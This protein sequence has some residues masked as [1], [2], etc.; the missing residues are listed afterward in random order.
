[1]GSF[2]T[3]LEADFKSAMESNDI[4]SI[5]SILV[6]FDKTSKEAIN[7]ENDVVKKEELIRKA[8]LLIKHVKGGYVSTGGYAEAKEFLKN[9]FCWIFVVKIVHAAFSICYCNWRTKLRGISLKKG[10][11]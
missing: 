2:L 10:L 6:N 8:R 11:T 7:S 3:S 9:Y 5:E 4:A 1:M